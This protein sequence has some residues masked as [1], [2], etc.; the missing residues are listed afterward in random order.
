MGT[1]KVVPE[2]SLAAHFRLTASYITI[3]VCNDGIRRLVE[4]LLPKGVEYGKRSMVKKHR[5]CN[6]TAVP[7]PCA[8]ETRTCLPEAGVEDVEDEADGA[9]ARNNTLDKSSIPP[10]PSSRE[11]F[12]NFSYHNYCWFIMN[13]YGVTSLIE[14]AIA[15]PI[16]SLLVVFLRFYVRL[17]MRRSHIG[18][19]DWL[20]LIAVVSLFGLA[21]M[22]IIGR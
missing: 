11:P 8:G 1:F 14:T 7:H 13:P 22:Q 5:T 4:L 20:C 15:L 17:H 12:L 18:V 16:L 3:S 19:D 6:V 21:V 10:C 2:P 9:Q